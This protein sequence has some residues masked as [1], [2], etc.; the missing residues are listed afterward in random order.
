MSHAKQ[1]PGRAFPEPFLGLR[2]R[3]AASAF[4]LNGALGLAR[5]A[6]SGWLGLLAGGDQCRARTALFVRL[7]VNLP[8]DM[9]SVA[10]GT[11]TSF[12][13]MMICAEPSA[14]TR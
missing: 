1:V 13:S 9:E 8:P 3:L 7:V 5:G 4:P 10:A 14:L 11:V 2:P 12:P 6:T